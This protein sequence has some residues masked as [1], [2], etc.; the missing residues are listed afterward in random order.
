MIGPMPPRD[1]GHRLLVLL[2]VSLCIHR[3]GGPVLAQERP[4]PEE[5]HSLMARFMAAREAH[6]RGD[7]TAMLRIAREVSPS[8]TP[9]SDPWIEL[10]CYIAE[11]LWVLWEPAEL[12]AVARDV[13]ERL[14]ERRR[15]EGAVESSAVGP[16]NPFAAHYAISVQILLARV[17]E[18]RGEHAQAL[19]LL[20][21]ALADAESG[22]PLFAAKDLVPMARLDA[23]QNL[24]ALGERVPASEMLVS[25]RDSY[26]AS[27][28]AA[29]AIALLDGLDRG[30]SA[31]HGKYAADPDHERRVEAVR[32][33][34]PGARAYA[35]RAFGI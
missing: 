32:A 16:L 3:L 27:D 26:P 9:G 17:Y 5:S 6:N 33:A 10:R 34:P 7:Q 28:D 19:G 1:L 18:S 24:L 23:A 25:L 4:N 15:A 12:E 29:I 30:K 8:L 31:A 20:R 21:S 11:A 22:R 2:I 13:V 14:A 35:A